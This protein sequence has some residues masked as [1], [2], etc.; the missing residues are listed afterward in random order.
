MALSWGSIIHR[1]VGYGLIFAGGAW[2]W[3]LAPPVATIG[4][5]GCALAPIGWALDDASTPSARQ[6]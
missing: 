1:G 4:L 3:W 2:R 6:S 5:L